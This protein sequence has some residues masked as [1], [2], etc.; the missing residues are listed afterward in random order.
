MR[1]ITRGFFASLLLMFGLSCQS[2]DLILTKRSM[3]FVGQFNKAFNYDILGF[4]PLLKKITFSEQDILALAQDEIPIGATIEDI[5]VVDI[6]FRINPNNDH[7]QGFLD[8]KVTEDSSQAT[9]ILTIEDLFVDGQLIVDP[10]QL[11]LGDDYE[12]MLI[13][14]NQLIQEGGIGEYVLDLILSSQ[15][16]QMTDLDVDVVFSF[17]FSFH[18]CVD[19]PVGTNAKNCE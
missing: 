12:Q 15:D 14:L 7:Q 3:Q 2:D 19:V 8:I 11:N 9:D 17:K 4:G 13:K 1:D 6:G 10:S 18:A 16:N 5:H